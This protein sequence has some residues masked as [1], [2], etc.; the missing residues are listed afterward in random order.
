M[1]EAQKPLTVPK[2]FLGPPGEF[3]PT[4]IM[5]FTAIALVSFS[6]CGY[7]LWNW[8]DPCCFALNVL[9][10]HM[11]GTVI[12]DAS[13]NAAHRNRAMNAIMG[14]GSALMLGFAFPVFTRVHIQH[15]ANVN[16]PQN[17]PDHFVS[18][19]G[20]LWLIAARFF[21]SRNLFL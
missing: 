13:H 18:T 14:H 12:H 10:L 17:D 8:P 15:H 11:V 4:L 21:L 9:A 6:T 1:S 2:E 3:N 7:W 20:P 5:F 19:G 16:D